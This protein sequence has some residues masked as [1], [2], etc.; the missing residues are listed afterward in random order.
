MPVG[1]G[2]IEVTPVL[3]TYASKLKGVHN[4]FYSTGQVF[5]ELKSYSLQ[6]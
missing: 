2:S 1:R 6:F 5:A 4:Q 3:V